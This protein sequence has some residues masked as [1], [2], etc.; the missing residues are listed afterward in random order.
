MLERATHVIAFPGP[1]S[2]WTHVMVDLAN[3]KGIDT[4]V[5]PIE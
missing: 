1:N 3:S 5:I 4:T 2:K